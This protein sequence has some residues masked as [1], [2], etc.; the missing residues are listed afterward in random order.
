MPFSMRRALKDMYL[1]AAFQILDVWNYISSCPS[2]ADLPILRAVVAEHREFLRRWVAASDLGP[3]ELSINKQALSMECFTHPP[4]LRVLWGKI[5]RVVGRIRDVWAAIV[6]KPSWVSL[7]DL[8]GT[9]AFYDGLLRDL[10]SEQRL[11]AE[12]TVI[13]VRVKR[14]RSPSPLASRKRRD[15][16]EQPTTTLLKPSKRVPRRH[17]CRDEMFRGLLAMTYGQSNCPGFVAH[18]EEGE[19]YLAYRWHSQCWLAALLLPQTDLAGV[20]L[21]GTLETL[22]LLK[23][24]PDSLAF[25]VDTRRLRWRDGYENGGPLSYRQKFP[26]AFFTGPSFPDSGAVDWVSASEL[27]V[28]DESCLKPSLIPHWRVVRAF[29]EKRTVTRV[30]RDRIGESPSSSDITPSQTS[31]LLRHHPFSDITMDSSVPCACQQDSNSVPLDVQGLV[32]KL[33]HALAISRCA[34]RNTFP[35][36]RCISYHRR[37]QKRQLAGR[38]KPARYEKYTSKSSNAN[39]EPTLPTKRGSDA[40]QLHDDAPRFMDVEDILARISYVEVDEVNL[41]Q[42]YGSEGIQEAI[43]SAVPVYMTLHEMRDEQGMNGERIREI[44]ILD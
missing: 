4:H 31:P 37:R 1:S 44:D 3:I 13:H 5:C 42:C 7:L 27:R 43:D 39:T 35:R 33:R 19:L 23:S 28:L 34:H 36:P 14:Q 25:D 20:G 8:Q 10:E 41:T 6:L 18:P 38:S 24:L 9:M 40:P 12:D 30:L 21:S 32:L 15:D 17:H 2:C 11:V 29:L 26:V 22:G 16:R